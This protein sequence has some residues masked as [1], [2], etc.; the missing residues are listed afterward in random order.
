[1]NN[2]NNNKIEQ[3]KRLQD[4]WDGGLWSLRMP[5]VDAIEEKSE[6]R[7]E[8]DGWEG[9]WISEEVAFWAKE[10]QLVQKQKP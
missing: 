4:C 5:R 10:Q 7:L 3:N 2:N 1:M 6:Q 9:I 8:G